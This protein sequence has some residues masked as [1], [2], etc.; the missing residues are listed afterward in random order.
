LPFLTLT[1]TLSSPFYVTQTPTPTPTQVLGEGAALFAALGAV[2]D[3]LL[4]A[5]APALTLSATA[6]RHVSRARHTAQQLTWELLKAA[7]LEPTG[8][9]N[10]DPNPHPNPNPFIVLFEV[11]L[12]V[13]VTLTPTPTLFQ[14]FLK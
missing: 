3:D 8:N 5:L 6:R 2:H 14:S 12:L 9:P 4:P 11:F 1:L 13:S 7:Y 10:P